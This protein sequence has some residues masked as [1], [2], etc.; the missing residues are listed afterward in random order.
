MNY[1]FISPSDR[2]FA[3]ILRD[4]ADQIESGK[5]KPFQLQLNHEEFSS[6]LKFI[7]S[8]TSDFFP[9]FDKG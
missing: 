3:Q 4:L 1:R 5:I 8:R 9:K 7:F 6:E 2:D